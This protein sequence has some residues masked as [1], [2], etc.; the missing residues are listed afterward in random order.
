MLALC[1]PPTGG[2]GIATP[3]GWSKVGQ[4]H[5][6]RLLEISG[7]AGS[8]ASPDILW[9][10]NDSG[11]SARVFALT[12]LGDVVAEIELAGVAT[13]DAEDIAVGPGPR[14]AGNAAWLYLADIG[15]NALERSSIQ[16]HRLPE[17]TLR[18]ARVAAEQIDLQYPDGRARNAETLLVDPV[19]GDVV[20]VT[21]TD[22]VAEVF[23]ATRDALESGST[24]LVAAGTLDIGPLATG[25]AV[26]A[27]G[28]RVSV[29]TKREVLLWDRVKGESLVEALARAPRL[30][31][32]A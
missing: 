10:H 31:M 30:R 1:D 6:R 21:K 5:D 11:D 20:I 19:R 2:S 9:V 23:T 15:D 32:A 12:H 25:G 8:A 14:S 17:P 4:V 28:L 27:D 24:T 13:I 18:D 16:L 22:G 7:A 3:A 26:S 29:R